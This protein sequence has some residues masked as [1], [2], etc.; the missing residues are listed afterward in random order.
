MKHLH[1]NACQ[2][3]A[4]KRTVLRMLYAI[5]MVRVMIQSIFCDCGDLE[6]LLSLGPLS[7]QTT[8]QFHGCLIT[9]RCDCDQLHLGFRQQIHWVKVPIIELAPIRGKT[10]TLFVIYQCGV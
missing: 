2:E 1:Y 4:V 6:S 3:C 8:A 7:S 9:P 5:F 10:R